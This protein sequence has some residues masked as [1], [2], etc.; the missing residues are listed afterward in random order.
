MRKLKRWHS[1][2]T[3]LAVVLGIRVVKFALS[4]PEKTRLQLTG[5][6]LPEI[7]LLVVK[8]VYATESNSTFSKLSVKFKGEDLEIS[9]R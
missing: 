2:N 6:S 1:Q 7:V 9:V 3:A 4:K 8:D 5:D